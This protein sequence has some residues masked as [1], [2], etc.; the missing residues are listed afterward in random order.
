MSK[1]KQNRALLLLCFVFVFITGASNLKTAPASRAEVNTSKH[2]Y[3]T[4]AS[5]LFSLSDTVQTVADLA[6]DHVPLYHALLNYWAQV[7]GRDLFAMRL[8]SLYFGLLSLAVT[9]RLARACGSESSAT[10]T[11][12]CLA[13]LAFFLYYTQITRL[14]ALLVLS[15]ATLLLFYWRVLTAGKRAAWSNWAGLFASSVAVIYT[16]LFGFILLSAIAAYHL[17]LAPKNRHWLHICLSIAAAGLCF[18]PWLPVTLSAIGGRKVPDSDALSLPQALEALSSIYSNGFPLLLV[19]AVAAILL[20]R[21]Q[22]KP[23][24]LYILSVAGACLLLMLLANAL[25][26]LLIAR[27]IRYTLILVV[28]VCCALAVGLHLLPGWSRLRLPTLALWILLFFAYRDSE[29]YLL[30]TNQLSL[31]YD[32]IPPY[33]VLQYHPDILPQASDFLLSMHPDKSIQYNRSLGFYGIKVGTWRSLIHIY[34]DESGLPVFES[35]DTRYVDLASMNRWHFPVWLVTNPQQTTLEALPAYTDHFLAHFHACSRYH[36]TDD[37]RIELYIRRPLPCELLEDPAPSALQYDNGTQLANILLQQKGD[38]LQ[39]YLHWTHTIANAYAYSLQLFNTDGQKVA[40][41]DD[42]IGGDS[43]AR[44]S[45]PVGHLSAGDYQAQF[46]VYDYNTQETQPGTIV[47]DQRR[48]ER[49][50]PVSVIT[51]DGG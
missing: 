3:N 22:L 34:Y 28:P 15:S 37:A 46:I 7:T 35:T 31:H 17:L 49:A 16:H 11:V 27:R 42:V 36:E 14:Y 43:L 21:K 41:V 32:T 39:V 38:S 13:I 18:L 47:A 2:I 25:E 45:I 51:L 5:P 4:R 10:D 19:I 33:H 6:P 48:F 23:A 44:Q 9:Y 50:V 12:L 40:Q 8:L 29:S 24:Q 20:R 30:Y 1:N 26:P